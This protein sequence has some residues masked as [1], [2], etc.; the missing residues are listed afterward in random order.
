MTS[1]IVDGTEVLENIVPKAL[2]L[3][4]EEASSNQTFVLLADIPE[5]LRYLAECLV[6]IRQFV[7]DIP[8][9]YSV[10]EEQDNGDID[11]VDGAEE[12]LIPVSFVGVIFLFLI[13]F[14]YVHI[15]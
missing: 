15:A 3:A 6:D 9:F 7:G 14:I 8:E 2:S 13:H 5:S 11:M 10:Q 1:L 12:H 4:E